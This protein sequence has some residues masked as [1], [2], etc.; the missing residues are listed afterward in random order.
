MPNVGYSG[1]AW[2]KVKRYTEDPEA[3]FEEKYRALLK[4]HQA[5]TAFLIE[6]V[7]ELAGKLYNDK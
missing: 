7:R 5:E 3:S 4:H 6:K 2:I 1:Y